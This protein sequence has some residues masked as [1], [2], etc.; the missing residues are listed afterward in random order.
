MEVL[1]SLRFSR[2][3]RIHLTLSSNFE[4][5]WVKELLPQFPRLQTLYV[6]GSPENL[7]PERLKSLSNS[8]IV[9]LRRKPEFAYE[10][11]W[12]KRNISSSDSLQ[13]V[14]M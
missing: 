10:T 8:A 9:V 2:V 6:E 7:W 5:H 13:I 3:Q 14:V 4:C 11:A 1:R 12:H